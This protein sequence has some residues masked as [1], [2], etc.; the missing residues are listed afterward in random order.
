MGSAAHAMEK[1]TKTAHNRNTD[2]VW[3]TIDCA[4]TRSGATRL[5]QGEHARECFEAPTPDAPSAACR[6]RTGTGSKPPLEARFSSRK[7]PAFRSAC[8]YGA[9][10]AYIGGACSA[11]ALAEAQVH[12]RA[13]LAQQLNALLVDEECVEL[14]GKFGSLMDLRLGE[15]R[16]TAGSAYVSHARA[17]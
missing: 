2:G 15:R 12:E 8:L 11:P 10:V 4:R 14:L 3:C 7:A 6:E 9:S 5:G 1:K 16:S 17:I 13:K